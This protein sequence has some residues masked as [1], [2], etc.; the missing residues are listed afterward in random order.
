MKA[1]LLLML[2]VGLLFYQTTPLQ[3]QAFRLKTSKMTVSGTSSLHDWESVVEKVEGKGFC[4]I[5]K[6]ELVDVKNVVIKIPVT[7]IKST[8]GR[9]MD[10]KTYDAFNYEKFPSIIFT[11]TS[12]KLNPANSTIDVKG[13]LSMAGATKP[14]DLKLSYKVLPNDELQITG[15][16]KLLMTDFKMEPP[17]AMMGT[18]KV[19]NEVVVT[20]EMTLTSSN[21]IL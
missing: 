18:I 10:N 5:E 13:T 12:Q 4:T 21:T 6:N 17:T 9:V 11:L 14:I 1:T 2:T 19:G 8:K 7:S 16:K 3:A 15:S 20:F